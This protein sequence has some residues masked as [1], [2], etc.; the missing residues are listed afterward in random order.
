[1]EKSNQNDYQGALEDLNKAD[2]LEPNDALTLQFR[3]DTKRI[4]D[5]YHEHWMI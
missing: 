4:L 3:G 2:Q 5:D 1:M